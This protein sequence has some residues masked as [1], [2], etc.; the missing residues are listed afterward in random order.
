MG[1]AVEEQGIVS[2]D[3]PPRSF[4]VILLIAFGFQ[5]FL[6]EELSHNPHIIELIPLEFFVQ[7]RR[8]YKKKKTPST[9]KDKK[10]NE[11]LW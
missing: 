4:R 9:L 5:H 2:F 1:A 8:H 11:M 7:I 3:I 6:T 10:K